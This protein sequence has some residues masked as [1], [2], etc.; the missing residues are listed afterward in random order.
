MI[1]EPLEPPSDVHKINV[2]LRSL[3]S[4]L[5]N[6]HYILTSL[7][8]QHVLIIDMAQHSCM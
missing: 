7:P 6:I 2:T 8:S 3:Y 5:A 1:C 4:T